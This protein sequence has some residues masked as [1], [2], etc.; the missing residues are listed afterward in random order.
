MLFFV[1]TDKTS[2]FSNIETVPSSETI[3]VNIEG[4]H[5][6][7]RFGDYSRVLTD[8]STILA[9]E[10]FFRD[11]ILERIPDDENT[12]FDLLDDK[13][14]YFIL[15][16]PKRK[17]F[18]V[19]KSLSAA[20][21]LYYYVDQKKREVGISTSISL[22][23]AYGIPIKENKEVIP[24]FFVSRFVAPPNTMYENIFQVAAGQK[25]KGIFRESS[26]ETVTCSS[27]VLPKTNSCQWASRKSY[28][29]TKLVE[30][31]T[32]SLS[33]IFEHDKDASLISSGGLDS[34][35]LAKIGIKLGRV[36]QTFSTSYPFVDS[37]KDIEKQY[38][39]TAADALGISQ[40]HFDA[41]TEEFL[42]SII[43]C[44]AVNEAPIQ[45]PQTAM[46][47]L[48]FSKGIPEKSQ[49]VISGYGADG[50]SG[51]SVYM[52][53][54]IS[55]FIKITSFLK[56]SKLCVRI[57]GLLK[58]EGAI[59]SKSLRNDFENPQNAVWHYTSYGDMQWVCKTFGVSIKE[60]IKGRLN[61][62][63][64][65]KN[66]SLFDIISFLDWLEGTETQAT[67]NRIAESTGKQL[68]FTFLSKK[69]INFFFTIP[70]GLK[71]RNPKYIIRCAALGLGV[72]RFIITRRKSGFGL[73][74]YIDLWATPKGIFAPLLRICREYFSDDEIRELQMANQSRAAT[75]W[76]MIVYSIWRKIMIENISE[77]ELIQLLN[78][79]RRVSDNA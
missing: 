30:Q 60:I 37:K 61:A 3:K 9:Y 2:P 56:L 46:L 54:I 5:S 45:W 24:E 58:K 27:Y 78:D 74:P 76:S 33:N 55:P 25:L 36:Q 64:E 50:I 15:L 63:Q 77:S 12:L 69:M 1:V 44:I 49:I 71:L 6:E 31:L 13:L 10:C 26:I 16:K 29:S 38:A 57:L 59:I 40:K 7:I 75:L 65:L 52:L 41:T 51:S 42:E 48:L 70:W 67:W 19:A 18:T 62:I 43:R 35:V 17:A 39:L 47:D 73:E 66:R 20:K 79:S 8:E 22:L 32:E 53:N 68:F 72:P 21:V 4:L 28:Y 11:Q 14:R 34:S 23:R